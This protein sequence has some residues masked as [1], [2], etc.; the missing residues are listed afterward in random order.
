MEADAPKSRRANTE[1]TRSLNYPHGQALQGMAA[2]E[3]A[4]EDVPQDGNVGQ[5]DL[6]EEREVEIHGRFDTLVGEFAA[7]ELG[8]DERGCGGAESG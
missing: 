7:D 4:M 2:R 3:Q 6:L 8:D 1:A 5:G